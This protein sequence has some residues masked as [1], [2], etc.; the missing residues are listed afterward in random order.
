MRSKLGKTP[1]VDQL[2]NEV[3]KNDLI[4]NVLNKL[5]QLC[6]DSGKIPS[7]WRKA[8]ISPIPKDEKA[9]RRIPL[10]YRGISLICCSAKLYT[11]MLNCRLEQFFNEEQLLVD[12]QNGFF[13]DRNCQ[14]HI[15]I[16]DSI[17]IIDCVDRDFLMHKILL[18]GINGKMY[19]AIKTIYTMILTT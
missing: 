16:L 4:I 3:F 5:F 13:K 9:D 11:S 10:N 18:A 17:I 2:P 6:L 15:Y 8:L 7:I 1:G 14:D 12:E 19:F